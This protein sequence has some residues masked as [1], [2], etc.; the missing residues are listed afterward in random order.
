MQENEK[1]GANIL[2]LKLADDS[3]KETSLRS[4]LGKYLVLYFYPKDDTPGC[5]VEACSFR[6]ANDEINKLPCSSAEISLMP[7]DPCFLRI[8]S[9]AGNL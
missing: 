2:D 3:G 6:D 5:T 9:N 1:I 4:F 8:L 7:V